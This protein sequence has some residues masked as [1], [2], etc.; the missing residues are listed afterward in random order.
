VDKQWKRREVLKHIAA[1]STA[2]LLPREP[3]AANTTLQ[4]AGRDCEIQI[5]SLSAHTLRLSVLPIQLGG[6]SPWQWLAGEKLLGTSDRKIA[7]R[8]GH[9]NGEVQ[10]PER[11]RIS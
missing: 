1:A 3:A 10:Q 4:I 6:G 7:G 9:T 5:A 2:I 11:G 8:R